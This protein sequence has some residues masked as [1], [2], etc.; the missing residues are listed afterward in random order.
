LVEHN[1][2]S[3]LL[4]IESE[5]VGLYIL[6]GE[7]RGKGCGPVKR[8]PRDDDNGVCTLFNANVSC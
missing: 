5:A 3:Q 4:V 6:P 2:N 7:R 8:E 1:G